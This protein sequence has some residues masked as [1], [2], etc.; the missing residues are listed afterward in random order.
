MELLIRLYND[1]PSRIGIKYT[2]EYQAARS[3][4]DL[5]KKYKGEELQIIFEPFNDQMNLL[6]VT[7]QTG[8]RI[9]YKQ[10]DYK[11]DQFT[12]FLN[13]LRPGDPLWFVHIYPS[14]NTLMVAK[15]FRKEE[16][17]TVSDYQL[18]SSGNFS[19]VM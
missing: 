8:A 11:K 5:V 19:D 10:L 18:R 13:L 16:F 4:E 15:P 1:K 9:P 7:R 12:R 6:L 14:G 17:F 2:Y 3:Y